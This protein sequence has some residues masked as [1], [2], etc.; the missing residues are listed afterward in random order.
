M[1]TLMGQ[2][3]LADS[4]QQ[5]W[6]KQ[7]R[8]IVVGRQ[9]MLSGVSQQA[10]MQGH[11]ILEQGGNAIDA[12]VAILAACGV[13][14][15]Q[16]GLGG[17]SAILIY[18]AKRDKVTTIDGLGWAP[19]KATSEFYMEEVG[20]L[21]RLGPLAVDVP[22]S[23]ASWIMAL[24]RYGTMSLTEVLQPAIELAMG[25]V[26][27]EI[28]VKRISK[29]S[30][31]QAILDEPYFASAKEI[32]WRDGE[33]PRFGEILVQRDLAT[34]YRKLAAAEQVHLSSGRSAALRAAHD[35]FYKGEIAKA[36]V[37]VLQKYGGIMEYEDLAEFE[38]IERPPIMITYRGQ[39]DVYQNPPP[40]QG[41][42]TL[43]VLNILEGYDLKAMGRGAEYY[44]LLSQALN[45]AFADRQAFVS[46][47]AFV[48]IPMKGMLSKEYAAEQRA[49]ID[50]NKAMEQ[51]PEPGNPY[52]YDPEISAP[53]ACAGEIPTLLANANIGAEGAIFVYDGDTDSFSVVDKDR[54]VFAHTGSLNSG[55][56]AGIIPPGYGFW[57]NNRINCYD[58]RPG[59]VNE[60][61]P[62][63][64][65][66]HTVQNVFV[67]KD[68]R[69]FMILGTPGGD[70]QTQGTL[71][72]FLNYVEFG[73]NI[74]EAIEHARGINTRMC[75]TRTYPY[76][77]KGD[78]QVTTMTVGQEDIDALIAKGHKVTL[79]P[80]IMIS[81]NLQAIVIDYPN[82][83][84]L[85]GG[86]DPRFRGSYGGYTI[87]W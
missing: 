83:G 13:V 67:M 69:P 36:I 40:T 3:G 45:L 85:Q 82:V 1:L 48:S 35:L 28:V 46:D 14:C 31:F 44:H 37:D 64:R 17:D 20:E 10:L 63:K 12:G 38:A 52:K 43:E 84:V 86:G 15:P 19:R 4:T 49:R 8:Q 59:N 39:Y 24:D 51:V 23:F 50:P 21:P 75:E 68:G 33:P 32:F 77:A 76:T 72:V 73:M 47:P 29:S 25:H 16:I 60:F 55:A 9:Y 70:K 27:D 18:D 5:L 87:G 71:Q 41:H 42:M 66:R 78:L 58:V 7:T 22:G 54:N 34:T 11:K 6:P 65:T 2:V 80:H 26:V 81:G 61:E 79:L 74:Q 56:G 62:H 53:T 57:L 30:S